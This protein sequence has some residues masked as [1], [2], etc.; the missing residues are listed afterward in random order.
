ME[1]ASFLEP[2]V[3]VIVDELLAGAMLLVGLDR[4]EGLER[5][6]GVTHAVEKVAPG[7][8]RVA[9]DYVEGVDCTQIR[10]LQEQANKISIET[11]KLSRCVAQAPCGWEASSASF[12]HRTC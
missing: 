10:W 7:V 11:L 4:E 9:V 5:R 12:K 1:D 2:V 6:A 3:K 8:T